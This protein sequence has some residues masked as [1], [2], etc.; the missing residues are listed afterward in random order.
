MRLLIDAYNALHAWLGLGVDGPEPSIAN[1]ADL[2][3]RS[4]Y[5]GAFSQ[6][7]CDGPSPSGQHARM[8]L[9]VPGR[10]LVSVIYAGPGRDAD[11]LI[12]EL[13]ERASGPRELRLVSSDRRLVKAARKRRAT[14]IESAAFI[15]EL[16]ADAQRPPRPAAEVHADAPSPAEVAE[17]M[18]FFGFDPAK[19][20]IR[21]GQEDAEQVDEESLLAGFDPAEL[22]MERWLDEPRSA[23]GGGGGASGARVEGDTVGRD[24]T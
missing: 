20:G 22:E 24:P 1:M 5:A 8:P 17:W 14:S 9:V 18:R 16:L 12:E 19:S 23:G 21:D 2:I 7:I 11:S 13:I 6:L 10:R 15:L 4:R 3:G